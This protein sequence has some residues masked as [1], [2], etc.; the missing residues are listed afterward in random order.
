MLKLFVCLFY[1]I[2]SLIFFLHKKEII[3]QKRHI[4]DIV[5]QLEMRP[6]L[7]GCQIQDIAEEFE[8]VGYGKYWCLSA[9]RYTGDARLQ[10]WSLM[11]S[12]GVIVGT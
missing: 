5:G 3:K 7:M 6:I 10:Q 1:F 4:Y 11:D 8:A 12:E 2:F 9:R